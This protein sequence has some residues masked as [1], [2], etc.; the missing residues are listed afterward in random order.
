[1]VVNSP[2]GANRVNVRNSIGNSSNAFDGF[3]TTIVVGP[4]S[5]AA[6]TAV[7]TALVGRIIPSI[8]FRRVRTVADDNDDDDDG[9]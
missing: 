5:T 3:A 6:A 7:A 8:H 9:C 1:M 2:S 4:I